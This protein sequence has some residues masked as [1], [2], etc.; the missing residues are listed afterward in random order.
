MISG[1]IF[2]REALK[3]MLEDKPFSMT[4]VT[5]DGKRKRMGDIIEVEN[6]KCTWAGQEN[7]VREKQQ[8]K[9]DGEEKNMAPAKRTREPNHFENATRNIVINGTQIRKVHIRL[10]TEFN[11]QKVIW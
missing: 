6:A 11:G 8:G 5:Y 7:K 10:I 2:L 3:V 1:T 9:T 4:F